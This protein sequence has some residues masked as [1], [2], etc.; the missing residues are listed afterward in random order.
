VFRQ[1][2]VPLVKEMYGSA[3]APAMFD[4]IGEAI[5]SRTVRGSSLVATVGRTSESGAIPQAADSLLNPEGSTT[6]LVFGLV[7]ETVR[8]SARASDSRV[9]IADALRAPSPPAGS[10]IAF[11][12]RCIWTA[13]TGE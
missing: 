12:T 7:D 9:D 2:D 13:R 4:A 11:S 6:V 8:L 1:A 3:F 5:R 10:G